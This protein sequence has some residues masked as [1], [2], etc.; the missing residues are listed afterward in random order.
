MEKG[1]SAKRGRGTGKF[2]LAI[3]ESFMKI[4]RN[5]ERTHKKKMKQM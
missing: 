1:L 5:K 4:E 2:F 3:G